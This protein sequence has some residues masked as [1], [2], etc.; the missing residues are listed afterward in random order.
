MLIAVAGPYSADTEEK[1]RQNL[2]AMNAAAA[3]VYLKGHIPVIGINAALF[4]A[5]EPDS[6]IRRDALNEISFA[7]VE[8]CDAI[9]IIGSSPGAD[10][11]RRIIEEKGLPV[12]YSVDDI[13]ENNT[14]I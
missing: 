14:G 8:K 5:D 11:E 9:H 13:P 3:R 4:V 10:I 1:R 2:K 6:S 12:Y 7:V